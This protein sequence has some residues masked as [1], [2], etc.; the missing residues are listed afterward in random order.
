MPKDWKIGLVT[1]FV[2]ASFGAVW[3]CTHLQ[4]DKTASLEK[5]SEAA[6]FDTAAKP[7]ENFSASNELSDTFTEH[8]PL[9][10][11]SLSEDHPIMT[12]EPKSGRL[13]TVEKGDTLSI[14]AEK[15]YGDKNMWHKIR[16]ANKI[17][18]VNFLRPGTELIV[19]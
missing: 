9:K 19:P 17:Q 18:N 11:S 1:G 13:Y 5:S 8:A 15:V 16:D 2:L 14:I 4:Q 12:S 10:L 7:K 3:F 6:S